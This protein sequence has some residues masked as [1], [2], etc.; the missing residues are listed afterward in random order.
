MT[1]VNT[2]E[3]RDLINQIADHAAADQARDADTFRLAYQLGYQAAQQVAYARA[4]HEIDEAWADLARKIR[5]YA[6]RPTES[7]LEQR[8]WGPGG[9]QHFADPRPGDHPGG[10][11]TWRNTTPEPA[12]GAC[13]LRHVTTRGTAA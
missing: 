12:A 7:E 6:A 13:R 9:R 3:A 11:I 1:T 2:D 10:P 8:R 5:G 4:V